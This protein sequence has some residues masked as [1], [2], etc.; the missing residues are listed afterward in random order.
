[1]D[2]GKLDITVSAGASW[3]RQMTFAVDGVPV[4][5]EGVTARAQIR[6]RPG[7]SRIFA[8]VT[9][10][11]GEDGAIT[12]T[13]GVI[14]VFFSKTALERTRGVRSGAAWDLFV[15]WPGGTDA[16]RVLAGTV[17]IV[18]PVTEPAP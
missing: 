11:P 3:R 5:L 15:E 8:T 2:T 16:D 4:N 10:T 9:T 7:G 13:P 17:R 14:E 1:M 6:N 12:V 18:Q